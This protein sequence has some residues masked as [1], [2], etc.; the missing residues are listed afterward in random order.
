MKKT[1]IGIC[2]LLLLSQASAQY[3]FGFQ[4][5]YFF[6]N[7]P[8]A[9]AEAMGRAHTAIGGNV[10]SLFWNP[11]GIGTIEHQEATFSTSAPFYA[12]RNSDYYFLGI[13]RRVHDKVVVALSVNQFA[14]GQTTFDVNINGARYP[15]EKPFTTNI[16]LSAAAE[17][18]EGL[19]VGVNV[20][21][22][23]WK[24]FDDVTSAKSILIDAGALY[25]LQLNGAESKGQK[26]QLGL[27]VT[28]VSSA[29]L[30]FASPLG[31][32]ATAE[33]PTTLRGGIAYIINTNISLPGA[34]EGPLALTFTTDY[35]NVLNS[36]YR[37]T[38]SLGTEALFWNVFA[39][40][41]GYLTQNIN[42]FGIA[43]NRERLSDFTYGFGFRIP[44]E[45]LTDGSLPF[46]LHWDYVSLKQPPYTFSGPRLPSMR[47]FSFR[48]VFS[49]S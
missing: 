19:H 28:N 24:T 47:S 32:E 13:A 25:R 35:Q 16:A 12:L 23:I 18:I 6:G 4:Q 46:A 41:M 14:I 3:N 40:R 22:F 34:G 42:N 45:E 38:F 33:F 10:A 20:N 8:S 21:G 2:T 37:N 31:D 48:V 29:S 36:S 43:A 39:L 5:E 30:T 9:Q 27:G 44:L 17:P 11:A 15:A 1:L 7:L 26:L 49:G